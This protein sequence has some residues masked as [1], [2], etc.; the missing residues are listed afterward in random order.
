[1]W[2]TMAEATGQRAESRRQMRD[3]IFG[4]AMDIIAERG[5]AQLG[6]REVAEVAGVARNTVYRYFPSREA[7]LGEMASREA[8]LFQKRLFQAAEGARSDQDRLAV[9]VRH[10]AWH[11]REH[12]ILRQLI[13]TEPGFLLRALRR[14]YAD[15]RDGVAEVARPA[16]RESD[17]VKAGLLSEDQ[18]IDWL[19]RLLISAYLFP[20]PNPERM[21]RGLS[22]LHEK[23]VASAGALRRRA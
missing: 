17:L 6:M 9:I 16:A 20:D 8:R 13:E 10:A 11:V 1:M 23:A 18:F 19:T 7:L 14:R 15:I 22:S 21:A 5:L 2:E 3:R 12:P 4:A